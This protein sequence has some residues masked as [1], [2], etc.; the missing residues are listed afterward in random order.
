MTYI[1]HITLSTGHTLQSVR[2][3]VSGE[4]MA[5]VAPWLA[6]LLE[7][8]QQAA[9]PVSG[10]SDYAAHAIVQ[11]GSL[12]ITISGPIDAREHKRPPLVTMGVARRSRQGAALWPLLTGP[13]MP[14]TKTGLTR[15]PE[16]WAAV[17][18]WSTIALHLEALPWLA[19]LEE[20]IAWAWLE[21]GA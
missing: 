12:L 6:V 3:R 1:T 5:R 15:P 8:G 2:T 10:L 16:P 19:D 7:S 17:Y 14:G 9:L 18:I 11:D 21:R 4:A 20:C 13:A